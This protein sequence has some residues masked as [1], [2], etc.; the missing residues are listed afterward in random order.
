MPADGACSAPQGLKPGSCC[1]FNVAAEA[2][3]HKAHL[4][5]D[6]RKTYLC[7]GLAL[8]RSS[9]KTA[10]R[11]PRR[12]QSCSIPLSMRWFF[13]PTA[14]KI[15]TS[16]DAGYNSFRNGNEDVNRARWLLV[17]CP[18]NKSRFRIVGQGFSPDKIG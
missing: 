12:S 13:A 15:P 5:D 3:T 16:E 4:C 18:G 7:D 9:S 11:L 8:L 1:G 10:F 17:C 14:D 6:T 2:A